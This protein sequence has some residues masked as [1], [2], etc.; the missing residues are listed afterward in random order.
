MNENLDLTKILKDV[1]K[2]TILWSPVCGECELEAVRDKSIDLKTTDCYHDFVNFNSSGKFYDNGEC[3][4]FPSKQNHDWST[5]VVPKDHK[6]FKPF[7]KVLRV[8]GK[9]WQNAL[10]PWMN[11]WSCD[12][13]SF[14]D[15]DTRT[16]YCISG[17]AAKDDEIIPYAGNENKVGKKFDIKD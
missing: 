17:F 9:A 16:H 2:G 3:V 13:Y 10:Y 12:F 1:P 8:N 15:K 5:F 4:L 6:V 7:E 11:I 14:Y